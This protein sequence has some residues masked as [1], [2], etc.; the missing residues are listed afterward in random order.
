MCWVGFNIKDIACRKAETDIVVYKV[1]LD[2]TKDSCMS[3]FENY[4][5]NTKVQPL[6]QFE[7]SLPCMLIRE[8]YHSYINIKYVKNKENNIILLTAGLIRFP[9]THQ[10]DG[11]YLAKFIIPKGSL[12]YKNIFDEVVS[13]S[14][15]YTGE[16][17]E[18]KSY[19]TLQLKKL[20][21][22][23]TNKINCLRD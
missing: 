17:Y 18:L 22:V 8:G 2:A 19:F 12:Y 20:D 10:L 21:S 23:L 6:I 14:I 15:K 1:V 16:Y 7:I 3:A 9:M 11:S 13:N 4:L 5:Y